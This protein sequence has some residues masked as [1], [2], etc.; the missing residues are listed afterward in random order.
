MYT[1]IH[2]YMYINILNNIYYNMDSSSTSK[3]TRLI[4]NDIQKYLSAHKNLPQ[5][6]LRRE[7]SSFLLTQPIP[8]TDIQDE[9]GNTCI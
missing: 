4:M 6:D 5:D 2:I 9:D 8:I 7:L 1:Y 3:S